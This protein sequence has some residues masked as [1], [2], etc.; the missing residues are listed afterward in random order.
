MSVVDKAIEELSIC[1]RVAGNKTAL[2][3]S[4]LSLCVF[5]LAGAITKRC[6]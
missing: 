4:G 5:Q 3:H 2:G 6:L 1:N